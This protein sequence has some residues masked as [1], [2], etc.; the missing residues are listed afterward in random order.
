MFLACETTKGISRSVLKC[1]NNQIWYAL[2]PRLHRQRSF[3]YW[4]S[5]TSIRQLI[6]QCADLHTESSCTYPQD[7]LEVVLELSQQTF[8]AAS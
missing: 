1:D 2:K 3:E 5:G 4:D 7:L 8:R 6:C